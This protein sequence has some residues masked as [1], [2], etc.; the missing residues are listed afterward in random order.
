MSS[1]E[2]RVMRRRLAGSYISTLIS[3]SLVLL[4]IGV[5]CMLLVNAR[6][7]SSYFKENM[8]VSVI[9][10]REASDA[11][12]LELM[13]ALDS[14]PFIKA[15]SFVSKEQGTREMREMLGDDFLS[16]F[17]TSPVPASIDVT[18][19]PDYVSSDSLAV[20]KAKIEDMPL[21]DEVAYQQSL[22]DALN[23]NLG[24]IAL[25]I[26]IFVAL[27]LFI[28]I[29][30]IG[31]TVRLSVF[32]HRFAV[33]A[34]RLVGATKSF[35]RRPFM[36]QAVVQGLL[37]SLIAIAVLVGGLLVIK[38][39]FAQMFEIFSLETLLTVMGTVV[40]C[41]VAICAASTYFIVGRL[42][43]LSKDELYA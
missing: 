15:A 30:L 31:N 9:M 36:A 14:L 22:V 7:V 13:A 20:V 11:Q 27:L 32:S 5:A 2:S 25:S 4:L 24:K 23:D 38:R 10:D 19:S 1:V 37:S 6:R 12:T 40:L 43:S 3:I 33:H 41:G 42:V 18:L 39:E 29:V 28:S 34:M 26:G 35:I 21:V 16:V 17:E 8:Q